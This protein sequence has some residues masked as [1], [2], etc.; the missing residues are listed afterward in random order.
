MKTDSIIS[1]TLL[2]SVIQP[3]EKGF[4]CILRGS[5][6][7]RF[8]NEKRFHYV[9]TVLFRARFLNDKRFHDVI[10]LV[11][12]RTRSFILEILVKSRGGRVVRG[13]WVNCQ[14]R[15]VLLIWII[16][17]RARAY[18]ACGRCGWGLFGHF[19]LVYLFSF[20]SP[21]LGDGPI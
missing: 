21:S 9:T 6:W 10:N 7:H 18:C 13:C 20:L 2:F 11:L 19:S 5:M 12:F 16:L 1:Q 3:S 15:G 8:L 4:F 14:C 17:N